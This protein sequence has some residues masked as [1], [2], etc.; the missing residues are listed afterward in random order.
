VKAGGAPSARRTWRG[1]GDRRA[2]ALAGLR[3]ERI[4]VEGTRRGFWLAR[5]SPREAP[6]LVVLHGLGMDGRDMAAFTG[7][8][9]RGPAAGFATVFPDGWER[10]WNDGVLVAREGGSDD[11]AFVA[12][13][14][15]R[16]V[17]DG[18][19]RPGAVFLVGISNGASFAEHLARHAIVPASGVVLVAGT[20]TEPSRELAP[21]PRSPAALLC[22][23]GTADPVVPY[24]GGTIGP[25]GLIGRLADRRRGEPRRLGVAIEHVARD[26]AA[27][28]GAPGA[29]AVERLPEVPGGL[30]V[31]RMSWRSGAGPPVELYRIEG[32][33]HGWPGG[34]QYL[35]AR[36][37][38]PVAGGPDA[39]AIVLAAARRQSDP[40]R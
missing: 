23:A 39:T 5:S 8:A 38:G 15:A 2:V 36:L 40:P 18:V 29:P 27:V 37:I 35:P 30:P 3:E 14:L 7:L 11:V 16:L 22:F 21:A 13:L 9:A 20:A 26:W 24:D 34:A 10:R 31:T 12:A 17:D 25:P 32:G 28:N 33:G 4:D 19:A 1:I 6:L